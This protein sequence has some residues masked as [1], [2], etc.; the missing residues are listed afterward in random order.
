MPNPES[1]DRPA[2]AAADGRPM[3]V[4][5]LPARN[6]AHDLPEYFESVAPIVDAVV[7]LDD[8]STD[9]TREILEGEP[10][11]RIV[12]RNPPRPSYRGWD[13]SANRNRLLD[14]AVALDP[15]WFL[16]LDSD[17]RLDHDDAA[18]LRDFIDHQAVEGYA[19]GMRVFRMIGDRHSWDR[20]ALWVYR[21]FA[22]DGDH[23]LSAQRLH[24]V[25]VPRSIPI[26]RWVQTTIRIQ[27]LASL[28]E[29][30]R[31]ARFEK[32]LEADPINRFQPSYRNLLD[33]PENLKTWEPRPRGL[34]V[35][36]PHSSNGTWSAA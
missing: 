15:A 34:A 7:G 36:Q 33:A 25:P 16:F 27:H 21:L 19:Y 28:T 4:G 24:F 11:V 22:R 23:S 17:E 5:L 1:L 26:E 29:R 12:L 9:E 10:L 31:R 20:C 32:Y 6:A 35:V 14:A 3:V 30:R 13:D 18:A 2:L 8:G